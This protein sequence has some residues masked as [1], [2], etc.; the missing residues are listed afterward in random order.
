[1]ITTKHKDPEFTALIDEAIRM[2][3]NI[4]ELYLLFYSQRKDDSQFWWTLA[5]EEEN[6]AALLK[7]VK[8]ME[9]MNV[10]IPLEFLPAKLEE[11][12][13]S[14]QEVLSAYDEFKTHPDRTRAF[15]FAFRI[16]NSAGELH[17]NTFMVNASDSSVAGVFKKLNGMDVDHA[18]RI[19]EYM[20]KNRIPEEDQN[21]ERS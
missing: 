18:A 1:M 14:N 17:Y 10:D 9:H 16:E 20:L 11:L 3:L 13:K 19:R 4:G 21:S 6:H 2:E 5:I 7:T 8:Q 15:Q 12:E